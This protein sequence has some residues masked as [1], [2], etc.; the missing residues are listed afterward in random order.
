MALAFATFTGTFA[1]DTGSEKPAAAGGPNGPSSNANERAKENA[2][3]RME[4]K[5]EHRKQREERRAEQKAK[6]EERRKQNK[7]KHAN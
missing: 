3:K 1:E 2:E 7:G 5:R 6:R 4:R